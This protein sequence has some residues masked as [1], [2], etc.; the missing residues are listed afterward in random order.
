M[1]ITVLLVPTRFNFVV[2]S[3]KDETTFCAAKPLQ[4]K[5]AINCCSRATGIDGYADE[6]CC[7]C[8]CAQK[9]TLQGQTRVWLL[10]GKFISNQ[11][12]AILTSPGM[13]YREFNERIRSARISCPTKIRNTGYLFELLWIGSRS[14]TAK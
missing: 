9:D 3:T 4:D 1:I 13:A 11:E 8:V 2:Q 5:I 6:T 10:R 12:C 14:C 7:C